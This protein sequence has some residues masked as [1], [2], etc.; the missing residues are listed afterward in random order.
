MLVDFVAT[1]YWLENYATDSARSTAPNRMW[2]KR[3]RGQIAKCAEAQA[4]RKGWPEIGQS[5]TAEEMEGKTIDS[6]PA[7]QDEKTAEPEAPASLP[8]YPEDKFD[9]HLQA[10]LDRINDPDNEHTAE[11]FINTLSLRYTLTD[12]QKARLKGEQA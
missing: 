8:A 1:E 6:V 11:D 5:P 7:T 9:L 2:G 4:L 12:G 3:P 10:R